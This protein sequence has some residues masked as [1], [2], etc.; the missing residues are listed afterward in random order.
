M[1][2][3]KLLLLA[4]LFYL[5]G[6]SADLIIGNA[7]KLGVNLG[8]RQF[9]LGLILG[10]LTS[11][12]E[13][14]VGIEASLQNIGQL[15]F[16]NLMGGV[17]VLLGLIIG[18]S[19]IMDRGIDVNISFKH[20]ELIIISAYISLPLW[21]MFDG[22]LTSSDGLLL[23]LAYAL[24][25]YYF[26]HFNPTPHHSLRVESVTSNLKSFWLAMLGVVGVIVLAKLILNITLPLLSFYNIPAFWG[27]LI[28][29]AL[30]TNLPELTLAFR[31]WRQ[32]EARDLSFG[33]LVGSAF[34]NPFVVGWLAFVKP[35]QLVVD[36]SYYV[37]VATLV[38]L[39][40]SFVGLS[41][42]GRRL[43]PREGWVLI[44]IYCL[45]VIIEMG[46]KWF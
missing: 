32:G 15:S 27:G 16:G 30:G 44:G 24:C 10:V 4:I 20:Q 1:I 35:M 13:L 28:F 41:Y 33:N 17:V 22:Q 29:F 38:I 7:K 26:I 31:S 36:S 11:T 8:I 43:T 39:L 37:F 12:P 6:K 23:V 2:V 34:A 25:V 45:F 42:S 14:I 3:V 46:L 19:V 5:I 9:W 40:L 21:L 18:V